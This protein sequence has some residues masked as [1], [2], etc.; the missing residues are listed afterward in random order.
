MNARGRDPLQSM[1]PRARVICAAGLCL[2]AAL[3]QAPVSVVPAL[4]TPLVVGL[5]ARFPFQRLLWTGLRLNGLFALM[6]L[7]TLP[8]VPGPTWQTFGPISVTYPGLSLVGMMVLKGNALVLSCAIFLSTME[9]PNLG[10]ALARLGVP[11]KFVALMMSVIRYIDV[12]QEEHGRMRLAM[13]ARG[14]QP[15]LNW[16]TLQTHALG[17]GALFLRSLER[18]ERVAAAMKCRGHQGLYL[19]TRTL[20]WRRRDTAWIMLLVA[21]TA[22]MLW[23]E[24]KP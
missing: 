3:A 24:W 22:G 21:V 6:A 1:D 14:F 17:V 16:L 20:H 18:A 13:R 12:L 9:S 15:R 19:A 5:S 23:L 8:F 4:L 10:H 2:V 7:S 11:A